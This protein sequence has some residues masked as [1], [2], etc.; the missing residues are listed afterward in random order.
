MPLERELATC[1]LKLEDLMPHSGS[2]GTFT[3]AY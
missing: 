2:V 1:A 3:L